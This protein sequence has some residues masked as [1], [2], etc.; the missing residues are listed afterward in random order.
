MKFWLIRR[1]TASVVIIV[2]FLIVSV[3]P[4]H[5]APPP[6]ADP[7]LAPWFQNLR[8]P[9]SNIGCCSIADC[10]AR[11]TKVDAEGFYEVLI[12]DK[13]VKVPPDKILQHEPNPT[14]RPIVCYTPYFGIMCFVRGVET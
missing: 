10:R 14:G 9:G 12:D 5:S 7:V 11:P 4:A 3:L 13:W 6:D 1:L 2:F 8:Q